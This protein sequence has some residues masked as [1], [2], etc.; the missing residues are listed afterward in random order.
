MNSI[1]LAPIV[2][3]LSIAPLLVA[4]GCAANK[5]PAAVAPVGTTVAT[6]A[7]ATTSPPKGEPTSGT[8][9]I[10]AEIRAA[11]GIRAEDAF[12]AFDSVVIAST[13]VA[14]LDAVALCFTSGPL[15]GR[16]MRLIGHA[17]PR[18]AFDYNMA[19]G[20]HRADS[21]EGYLDGRG[22]RRSRVTVTSRG[23]MDATGQDEG[24]WA[25]DRRV[26][27]QLGA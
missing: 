19:L 11:C 10:A 8:I 12:F 22:L 4:T 26:D 6:T 24:G 20:L 16:T 7:P 9:A 23:A 13:D 27:V 5:P 2:L 14:P 17:D 3:A 1:S 15:A 25:L 18:G 21:V